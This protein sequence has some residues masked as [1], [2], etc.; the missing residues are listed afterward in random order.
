MA[1]ETF[2]LF[3]EEGRDLVNLPSLGLRHHDGDVD[4]EEELDDD[5]DHEDPGP[6]Q[7]LHRLE[8]EPDEEVGGPVHHHRDRGGCRSAWQ[9]FV[10][11]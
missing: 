10:E 11:C 9:G 6:H 7:Q 2:D 3:P 1:A 4:D 8:A 5:E